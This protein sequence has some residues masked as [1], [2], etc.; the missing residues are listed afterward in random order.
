M[1]QITNQT[2]RRGGLGPTQN[3]KS[4]GRMW[5]SISSSSVTEAEMG[6]EKPATC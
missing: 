2:A 4:A 3:Q 5:T 6:W 1:T